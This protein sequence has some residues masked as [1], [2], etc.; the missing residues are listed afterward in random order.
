MMMMMVVMVVMMMVMMMT[1]AVTMMMR[2]EMANDEMTT[3]MSTMATMMRNEMAIRNRTS[4]QGQI[5][6]Y[7]F[8]VFQVGFEIQGMSQHSLEEAY[9]SRYV[10][11]FLRR[12]FL[13]ESCC[14]ET[15]STAVCPSPYIYP[16][17]T[18][19]V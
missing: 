18:D 1:M 13:R 4:I 6:K 16:F 8:N 17:N 12:N 5:G 10:L 15:I 7:N 14:R 3:M 2:N 11:S 9:V 19:A